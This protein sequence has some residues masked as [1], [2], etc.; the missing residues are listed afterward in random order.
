MRK[1]DRLNNEL[2]DVAVD[3]KVERGQ[4]RLHK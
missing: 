2:H 3:N 4:L 1:H